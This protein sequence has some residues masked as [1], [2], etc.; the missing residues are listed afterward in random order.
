MYTATTPT[1]MYVMHLHFLICHK[2]GRVWLYVSSLSAQSVFSFSSRGGLY[3]REDA[4]TER[5]KESALIDTCNMCGFVSFSIPPG[6]RE[7]LHNCQGL[8]LFLSLFMYLSFFRLASSH[9]DLT[10]TYVHTQRQRER[11]Y[12]YEPQGGSVVLAP[13]Y[14]GDV[15]SVRDVLCM[16]PFWLAS[17]P[18]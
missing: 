16:C 9:V 11:I 2:K 5:E 12:A 18:T 6:R 10:H 14:P 7:I 8:L 1:P 4:L 15:V 17:I 13:E 3:M